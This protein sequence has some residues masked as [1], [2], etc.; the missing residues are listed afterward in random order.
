MEMKTKDFKKSH[1]DLYG[2]NYCFEEKVPSDTTVILKLP[3]VTANKRSVSD[4]GW[5]V[6][7][8]TDSDADLISVSGTLSSNPL[9]SDAMWQELIPGED[10]NKTL[11]GIKVS[12]GSTRECSVCIRVILC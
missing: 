12:N 11:S 1:G 9:G 6:G 4:I 7:C 8:E 3:L 5:M 10:V 2:F